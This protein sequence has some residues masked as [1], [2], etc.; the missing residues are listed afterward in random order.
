MSTTRE[1]RRKRDDEQRNGKGQGDS[2]ERPSGGG[3]DKDKDNDVGHGNGGRRRIF[4]ASPL[5]WILLVV[6]VAWAVWSTA[7]KG[8]G[9]PT[10][11]RA[12]VVPTDSGPQRTVAVLPCGA[13]ASGSQKQ[14]G[15]AQGLDTVL[16]PRSSGQRVVLVPACAAG[17]GSSGG[18]SG[19]SSQKGGAA[20]VLPPGQAPPTSGQTLP[21]G[22]SGSGSSGAKAK[23]SQVFR[24]PDSS[25]AGIV[26]VVPCQGSKSSGGSSGQ[27]QPPAPP[28]S[29]S[30]VALA[31]TCQSSSGG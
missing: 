23:V 5:I 12:V 3:D 6:A 8:S 1:E 21:L 14:K 22:G 30:G 9:K 2:D 18:A 25:R 7:T 13:V 24:V 31:P 26:V 29:G 11:V 20:I 28:E 16:L 15:Q 27:A 17:G 19:G 10:P 4:T